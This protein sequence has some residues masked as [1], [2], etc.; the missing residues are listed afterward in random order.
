MQANS[1]SFIIDSS[2]KSDFLNQTNG[3][4]NYDDCLLLI[5]KKKS[6]VIICESTYCSLS[7]RMKLL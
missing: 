2:K 3:Y 5:L 7:P 6:V 1:L 4:F